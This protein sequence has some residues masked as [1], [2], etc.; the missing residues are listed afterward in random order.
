MKNAIEDIE[1]TRMDFRIAR[2]WGLYVMGEVA[3][4]A[5]LAP[6]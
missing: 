5:K 2:G 3:V 4:V 1:W 6:G